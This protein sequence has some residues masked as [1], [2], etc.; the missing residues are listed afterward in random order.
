ML[1]DTHNLHI[2]EKQYTNGW[3]FE[4]SLD[5]VESVLVQRLLRESHAGQVCVEEGA[6]LH[7]VGKAQGSLLVLLAEVG[8]LLDKL[9]QFYVVCRPLLQN[10]EEL[11]PLLL[12]LLMD[13]SNTNL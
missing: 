3:A 8:Q 9:R 12:L 10:S 5:N 13:G 11:L 7:G 1:T 2:I 4:H 6:R